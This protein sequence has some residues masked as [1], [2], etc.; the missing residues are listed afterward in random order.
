[1]HYCLYCGQRV[2]VSPAMKNWFWACYRND[3]KFTKYV[4]RICPGT[5]PPDRERVS[6]G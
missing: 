2:L 4:H 3:F 5:E 1:M 6:A